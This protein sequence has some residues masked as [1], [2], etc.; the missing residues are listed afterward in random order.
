MAEA[1][2]A[3]SCPWT[4]QLATAAEVQPVPGAQPPA[5]LTAGQP[6]RQHSMREG[7]FYYTPWPPPPIAPSLGFAPAST[8]L[9]SALF[10][11]PWSLLSFNLR[12]ATVCFHSL[13]VLFPSP[14]PSSLGADGRQLRSLPQPWHLDWHLALEKH[15]KEGR[16]EFLTLIFQVSA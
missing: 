1:R 14:P 3:L 12:V 11:L 2:A 16:K 9:T 4:H 5:P 15:W 13:T 7:P 8:C 10:I 6:G